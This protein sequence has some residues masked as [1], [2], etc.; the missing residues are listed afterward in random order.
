MKRVAKP[1]FFIVA[2]LIIALTASSILGFDTQFGDIKT[3]RIKGID[4]IRWGIDI[5]GGVEATFRPADGVDAT[6]EQLESARSVIET[7]LV[8]SSITDYE[9]YADDSSQR[10][11]VRFPWKED[12]TNYDPNEAIE[13]I[14]ATAKLTFRPGNSYTTV[15]YDAD[16]N[17][18]MKT[19][20][21]ETEEIL[22]DGSMITKAEPNVYDDNGKIQYVVSLEFNDEGTEKFKE[23]TTTYLNQTIS[24]WMDDVM[25]SYPNVNEVISEGKAQISGSFTAEEATA[26]ATKINAGAL[27]FSLETVNVSSI[28]PTLGQNSL[29]AMGI[30]AIIALC[31]ITVFMIIAFR[32]PGLVAVIALAGQMS[33]IIIAVSGYFP[34][35]N[36]FTMTLPGIAGMILSIGTGV[37]ANILTAERIREELKRGKS[38]DSA[39]NAGTKNSLSAIIDGNMTIIIVAVIL[40]LVFGPFNMLSFIFGL[41]TTGAIYAFGYTLLIGTIANFIMGIGAARLMLKSISGLKLLR[42][43]RLYGGAKNER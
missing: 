20:K 36:S 10:I 9:L 38:L 37:D 35:F 42:N 16:G 40:I 18:I 15:D 11:I 4:D 24:I 17:P 14:A 31:F 6:P 27:P 19:P 13:E 33:I 29:Y 1:V 25:L 23:A 32:I 34:V 39:I 43:P 7:R 21:D 8:S 26:L 5:K 2:L 22:L 41:S 30:A 12:T 28:S 3:T